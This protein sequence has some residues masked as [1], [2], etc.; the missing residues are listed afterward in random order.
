ML[1]RFGLRR[2]TLVVLTSLAASVIALSR[3]ESS[4]G[5]AVTLLLTRGLGQSMLSVVSITVVAK[6]FGRRIGPAMGAYSVM[7]SFLMA[8]ATGLLGASVASNGWRHAW[9][10]QGWFLLA[11]VVPII[12]LTRNS[13]KNANVEFSSIDSANTLSPSAT[14]LIALRTPCF[15][16]FTLSI[17]FFGLIS[18]GL[19]LFNQF[20][21][22]ERGFDETVFHTTL[23]I[24]LLSGM[25]ANLAT[26]AVAKHFP[27]E[28]ILAVGLLLL[29]AALAG[30][31]LVRTTTQVYSYAIIMGVAGAFSLCFFSPF[32]GT[33][34]DPSTLA[35]Y[36]QRLKW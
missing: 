25:V 18:S 23:V 14:L 1:D 12:F 34:S 6:W 24:G 8:A 31:P 13:P 33:R 4:L 21:L 27:L 32:G 7:M 10:A 16:V 3:V 20:V 17:S 19:S 15:W 28:R 5:V 35:K 9:S 30:F 22:E 36:R 29:A 26:G 11:L 2:V